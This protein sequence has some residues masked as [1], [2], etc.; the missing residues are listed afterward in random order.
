MLRQ[1]KNTSVLDC[2]DVCGR[3]GILVLLLVC[4]LANRGEPAEQAARPPREALQEH[5]RRLTEPYSKTSRLKIGVIADTHIESQYGIDRNTWK[6]TLLWWKDQGCPL[7]FVTGDLGYGKA[8]QVEAF[9]AA[10][11][12]VA[13]PSVVVAVMGNH[14]LD[15][16]GKRPWVDTVY[17]STVGRRRAQR[18]PG[19]PLLQLQRWAALAHH[20]PRRQREAARRKGRLGNAGE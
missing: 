13:G 17:P 12:Q 11:K 15:D 14:A 8:E 3:T 20:L 1:A 10:V 9:A 5:F 16:V 4:L 18:Q 2:R 7:G 19:S 6:E